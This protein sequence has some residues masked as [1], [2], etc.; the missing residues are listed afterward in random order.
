MLEITFFRDGAR[1]FAGFAA[2]GH[3]D[4]ADYGQDIV[5]AAVSAILQA[6]RLGLEHYAGG[7]L[8]AVQEPGSMRVVIAEGRRDAESVAAIVTTAELA[9]AQVV[10]RFPEHVSLSHE[11]ISES[12]GGG[13][14]PR[15][16]NLA[17]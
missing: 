3:T 6:A 17:E 11:A 1:R 16:T 2:F 14:S 10:R 15:V 12:V 8:E 9:V 13:A 7:D 4:F 5:C